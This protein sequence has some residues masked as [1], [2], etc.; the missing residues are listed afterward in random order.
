MTLPT[1]SKAVP[2]KTFHAAVANTQPYTCPELG[3]NPGLDESRFT[4]YRLPSRMGS[5]LV[6][7]RPMYGESP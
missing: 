1:Y 5:K 2:A 4:A 7:P 3:R 6:A